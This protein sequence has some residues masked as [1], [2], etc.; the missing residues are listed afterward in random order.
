MANENRDPPTPSTT[1]PVQPQVSSDD[2]Q[3]APA[4]DDVGQSENEETIHE[5]LYLKRHQSP[6]HHHRHRTISSR[7]LSSR[8]LKS[9]ESVGS[10][11]TREL[12]QF[13]PREKPEQVEVLYR[14]DPPPLTSSAESSSNSLTGSC[15]VSEA[16]RRASETGSMLPE[17]C[18]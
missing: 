18:H 11:V 14:R 5:R 1:P 4:V 2:D 16:S 9:S 12:V 7:S 6:N 3:E 17:H 15:R 8:A 13:G 10:I